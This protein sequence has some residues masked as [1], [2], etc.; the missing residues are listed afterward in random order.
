MLGTFID[1]LII[2]SITGLAIVTA[3]VWTRGETG[4]ALTSAAFEAAIPGVGR[5]PLR[6]K[7]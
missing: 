1:T 7:G 3:G 6:T 4:A 2:C 5:R